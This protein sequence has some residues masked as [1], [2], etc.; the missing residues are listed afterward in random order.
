LSAQPGGRMCADLPTR[1]Y[2]KPA[3]SLRYVTAA[4]AYYIMD[5][6][7]TLQTF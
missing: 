6:I 5:A 2:Y 4:A 1:R 7:P 3:G